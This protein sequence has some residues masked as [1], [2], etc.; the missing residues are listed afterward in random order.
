MKA[1][2][3]QNRLDE[4]GE[5]LYNLG[6]NGCDFESTNVKTYADAVK[7]RCGDALTNLAKNDLPNAT[8]NL[9]AAERALHSL[10]RSQTFLWRM[11]N[12]YGIP[13]FS[14]YLFILTAIVFLWYFNPKFACRHEFLYAPLWVSILG[15]LGAT[16]RGLYWTSWK[17]AHRQYEKA[18]TLSYL[19]APF[20]GAALGILLYFLLIAGLVSVKGGA[21]GSSNRLIADTK[22]PMALTFLAGYSWEW[23][24]SVVD[25]LTGRSK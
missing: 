20:V 7:D 19:A 25:R 22:L 15:A 11:A 24:F 16:L 23:V 3:I 10:V 14:Y 17:V 5:F 18:L 13:I 21:S 9:L 4:L 6:S 1:D 8:A 2:E 12:Y